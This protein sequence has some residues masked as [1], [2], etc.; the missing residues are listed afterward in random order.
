LQARQIRP[1]HRNL[2]S[3][4]LWRRFMG[5]A[6]A[7]IERVADLVKLT[8][9]LELPAG[10]ISYGQQKLVA[11]AAAL[12]GDPGLVVLDEPLAG[13]NPTLCHEIGELLSTCRTQGY[14]F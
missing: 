12:I 4:A 2:A 3:G 10:A 13:V 8:A 6:N 9:I 11:L 1:W 7:E 5:E 14:T